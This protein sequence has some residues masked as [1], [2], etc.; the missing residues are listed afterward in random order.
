[1]RDD[2]SNEIEVQMIQA[3]ILNNVAPSMMMMNDITDTDGIVW[4]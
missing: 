1:M 3:L 2:T 4:S